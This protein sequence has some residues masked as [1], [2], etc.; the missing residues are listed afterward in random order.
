MNSQPLCRNLQIIIFLETTNHKFVSVHNNI[1]GHAQLF[2]LSTIAIL[3]IKKMLLRNG[4]SAIAI[5]LQSAT[6]SPQHAATLP[7][8]FKCEYPQLQFRDHF[9]REKKTGQIKTNS[10]DA[11]LK[12][13]EIIPAATQ[14]NKILP[15]LCGS[16]RK[17]PFFWN[18]CKNF[19]KCSLRNA[20]TRMVNKLIL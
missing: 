10:A 16:V 4:N 6:S 12:R 19:A 3:Q 5:Y 13:R 15:S 17:A 1:G 18:N 20:C 2:M 7:Q 14:F 9:A 8:F 11:I